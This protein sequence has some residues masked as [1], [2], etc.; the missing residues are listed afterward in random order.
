M[1][2][3]LLHVA[4]PR[5]HPQEAQLP[6]WIFSPIHTSGASRL[7]YVLDVRSVVVIKLPE[8]GTLV[9]KHVVI[10]T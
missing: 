1:R 6:Q 7:K 9:M 8:D 3:K 10:G 4:A 5:C 2:Y